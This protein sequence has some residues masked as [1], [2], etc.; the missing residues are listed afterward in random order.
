MA[1]F[2]IGLTSAESTAVPVNKWLTFSMKK[3][4]KLK[5]VGLWVGYH[6]KIVIKKESIQKSLYLLTKLYFHN[7]FLWYKQT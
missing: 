6:L 4:Y 5:E 2:G 3:N 7:I 1:L